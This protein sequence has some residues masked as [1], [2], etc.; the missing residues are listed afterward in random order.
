MLD[1][2]NIHT[3]EHLYGAKYPFPVL[4]NLQCWEIKNLYHWETFFKYNVQYSSFL[5]RLMK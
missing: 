2:M 1:I 3:K 5:Q 4:P